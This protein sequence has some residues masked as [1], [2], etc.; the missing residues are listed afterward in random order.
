MND[1]VEVLHFPIRTFAQ[2]E[3]KVLATGLGYESLPFRSEEVGR[4]QLKL[5]ELQRQGKL[6]DYFEQYVL[7]D[8]AMSSGLARAA[9]SS[10]TGASRRSWPA[11]PAT[12]TEE[13]DSSN[14]P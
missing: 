8:E 12:G 5:L 6:V 7:S 2:F 4:D 1:V 11:S 9:N 13:S 10:S 14:A 3:R